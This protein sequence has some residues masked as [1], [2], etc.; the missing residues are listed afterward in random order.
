V[1]VDDDNVE[2][3]VGLLRQR[4]GDGVADRANAIADWNDDATFDGKL[5]VAVVNR[6]FL[7]RQPGADPFQVRRGDSLHLD[8][9]V[10]IAW[11][12]VAEMLLFVACC[13]LSANHVR[14]LG[15]ADDRTALACAKTKVVPAA[16]VTGDGLGF[17][18]FCEAFDRRSAE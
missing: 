9:I 18:G 17:D 12:D 7:R 11:I 6:R 14:R 2:W 10:A 5:C 3:K 4:A 13:L 1:V 15:Q 16:K 8:L